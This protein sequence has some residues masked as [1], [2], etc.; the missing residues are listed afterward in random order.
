MPRYYLRNPKNNNEILIQKGQSWDEPIYKGQN[1][2]DFFILKWGPNFTL[3]LHQFDPQTGK[4]KGTPTQVPDD[5]TGEP[6]VF[7]LDEN[8]WS[9][10]QTCAQQ[11]DVNAQNFL[12]RLIRVLINGDLIRLTRD[13]LIVGN[14]HA[15][16]RANQWTLEQTP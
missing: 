2:N 12:N 11:N 5:W 8:T 14:L 15:R 6:R 16:S 10:I 1:S 9:N 3:Q 7:G 13:S 4:L